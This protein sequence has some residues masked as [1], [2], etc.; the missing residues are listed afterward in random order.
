MEGADMRKAIVLVVLCLA[1]CTWALADQIPNETRSLAHIS[2]AQLP[3]VDRTGSCTLSVPFF[4]GPAYGD[5]L[6]IWGM[7]PGEVYKV[8]LDPETDQEG[9]G[10]CSAPFYPF[11]VTGVD[12]PVVIL[13]TETDIGQTVCYTVDI[14]C[15]E[16]DASPGVSRDCKGPDGDVLCSMVVCH[17]I[18]EDDFAAG[19]INIHADFDCCVNGPF[20][21][22]VH[23]DGNWTGDDPFSA[24]SVIIQYPVPANFVCTHC[25]VWTFFQLQALGPNTLPCW[26]GHCY[27][28]TLGARTPGP[29]L[30]S[31]SGEAG[32]GCE[33]LACEPCPRN[34]P[35]DDAAHPIIIDA[36]N[37]EG[38][39]DLCQ[40]C[41]DYDWN[42]HN[43]LS[44]VSSSSTRGGDIV[45][46]LSFDP[47]LTDEA[48]FQ[49]TLTP[50]CAD[51]YA[52]F[53][54]RS[55]VAVEASSFGTIP[56]ALGNPATPSFGVSQ[57]YNFTFTGAAPLG[58][59]APDI[60]GDGIA[61]RYLL[62]VDTRN[63]CCPVHIAY[64]GDQPLP[65]EFSSFTAVGGDRQ[66]SL[67]WVTA[68]ERN[69][70]HFAITRDG[71]ALANV[72][73]TNNATGHTYNLVDN[74]VENGHTYNY[75]LSA[76]DMGGA[77][78]TYDVI[79]SATP[80]APLPTAYVLEQN[81]PNPFNPTTSISYALKDA[82]L[83]SL[84]VYTID[85][86]EV[87]TLVNGEQP[88]GNYTVA[89]NGSDLASGVYL[90]TLKVN[91]FNATHKMV[92]MK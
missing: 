33:P 12:F 34:Y 6:S 66:V 49:L 36:P 56:Y 71:A 65:V 74:N 13:G 87:S 75:R 29:W 67:T 4:G 45:L 24:P 77:V 10:G 32:V 46:Q 92:L 91:G 53:R 51:P 26:W 21:V 14:E 69:L 8:Y 78:T 41:S 37:W 35:G 48:C 52:L 2:A 20:F 59:I 54:I 72:P 28:W 16:D 70:D 38:T 85:G 23:Y 57:T 17:T 68:S 18:T 9:D 73:A 89:F 19:I 83:V 82:G 60:D 40:Y 81:Y 30:I 50:E 7:S 62:Y 15:P 80:R 76:Y 44:G 31:A 63:C 47:T 11:H 27:D 55:W 86:R 5:S 64:T 22:G 39:F 43:G 84:T 90:Y 61:D 79:A 88:A 42:A 1:V 25:K 3:N 58:C